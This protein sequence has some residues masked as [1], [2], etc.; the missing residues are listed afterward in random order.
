M[1]IFAGCDSPLLFEEDDISVVELVAAVSPA[2]VGTEAPVVTVVRTA[3]DAVVGA[4][5]GTLAK[6]YETGGGSSVYRSDTPKVTLVTLLPYSSSLDVKGTS[7]KKQPCSTYPSRV[8][9][10]TKLWGLFT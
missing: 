5:V 8:A 1:P 6:L 3:L 10:Q 7:M 9:V 4:V 2:V